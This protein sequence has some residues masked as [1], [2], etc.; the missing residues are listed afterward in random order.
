MRIRLT[1]LPGRRGT[2]KLTAQYGDRLVC[3]RYR[4]DIARRKRYKT[5]ELIVDTVDWDPQLNP[6]TPV[7]VQVKGLE[8]Y[9]AEQIRAAGG[10]WNAQ[11]EL[12]EL[13]Y[14][15]AVELGLSEQIVEPDAIEHSGDEQ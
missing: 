1:L 3:V 7:L 8:A 13:R 9:T 12:W 2:K 5:V 14:A 11:F 15:A 6:E 10:V 4:Y